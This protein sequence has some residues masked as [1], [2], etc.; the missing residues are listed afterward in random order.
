MPDGNYC[1]DISDFSSIKVMVNM[2]ERKEH[3]PVVRVSCVGTRQCH[4]GW[5][6]AATTVTCPCCSLESE[7]I[8]GNGGRAYKRRRSFCTGVMRR[9]TI[10]KRVLVR[11]CTSG[12]IYVSGTVIGFVEKA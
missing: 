3:A 6:L 7:F 12:N 8:V 10:T 1:L 5:S 4:P 2:Q 9:K 11:N